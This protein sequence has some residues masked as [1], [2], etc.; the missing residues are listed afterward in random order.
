VIEPARE[1]FLRIPGVSCIGLGGT[2]RQGLPTEEPSI[3]VYVLT[4]KPTRNLEPEEVIPPRIDGVATNAVGY[5]ITIPHALE[6]GAHIY[7]YHTVGVVT[8]MADATSCCVVSGRGAGGTTAYFLLSADHVLYELSS[9][10]D[11][12]ELD[13]SCGLFQET[14]AR[15]TVD[16]PATTAHSRWVHA[17]VAL[18][19]KNVT[20]RARARGTPLTGSLDLSPD[21]AAGWSLDLSNKFHS[22]RLFV[23]KIG[24]R[25]GLTRFRLGHFAERRP[26]RSASLGRHR[27]PFTFCA[28][29]RGMLNR[30]ALSPQGPRC[31]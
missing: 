20:F 21:A 1:R 5:R 7:V 11:R 31:K 6:A 3:R 23:N 17:A 27:V 24:E 12:V 9:Q 13:F 30:S 29:C 8:T 26:L 18:L 28:R 2:Q 4:K 16:E 10:G 25:A 19:S 22:N 15:P 14:L